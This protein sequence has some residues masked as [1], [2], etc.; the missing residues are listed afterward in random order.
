VLQTIFGLPVHPLIVH[1]TVVVVP[2]AALAALL[3][4]VWPRFRGWAG[5]LTPALALAA[6]VLTPLSTSSGESL[7]GMVG[8]THLVHEH[9]ELA[10]MLIWWVIPLLVGAAGV[11]WFHRRGVTARRGLLV[12][13]SVLSV[14]AAVGTTVQ[15]VL[16][17]HSGAN[18]AWHGV[19]NNASSSG[20]E[21]GGDGD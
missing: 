6:V 14:V 13:A 21:S 4:A 18:A 16:V 7:E 20:G 12:A 15:V 19:A 9:A 11:W 10:D 3:A 8:D 5:I 2:A 17:G 1:A